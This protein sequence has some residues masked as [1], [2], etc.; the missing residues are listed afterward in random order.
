VKTPRALIAWDDE[1]LRP[2]LGR[3]LQAR[4]FDVTEARTAGG[5][6]EELDRRA[7]SILVLGYLGGNVD[8]L[9]LAGEIRRQDRRTAVI[10]LVSQS[11]EERA[12]SALR[13][14]VLDYF[15]PPF[16]LDAVV[17]SVARTSQESHGTA[18]GGHRGQEDREEPGLLGTSDSIREIKTYIARVGASDSTVLITGETGTGK[19]LTAAL[20]H[21]HSTRCLRPFVCINCAAIPDTLLESELFGFERGA[22]TGAHASRAGQLQQA[23][24]GTIFFDEIG[25]MTP[26]AQPKVLRAIETKEVHRV[27]G[28]S[29]IPV[30]VRVI[31]ATNQDLDQK[32]RDGQFRQ[33][34]FYRLDVARIHLPPLRHRLEDLPVLLEHYVQVFNQRF[35]RRLVGFTT[36]ALA[37]LL[38]YSWPGNIRELRN[39]VEAVYINEPPE[40]ITVRDLPEPFRRRIEETDRLPEDERARILS[41]LFATNWNKSQAAQ[42]LH[43]SRMTL[44]RKIARYRL[45]EIRN[46]L[47]SST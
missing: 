41:A 35:G 24:G 15:T 47:I 26:S 13:L 1:A 18:K 8:L 7:P 32:V 44:Y 46:A 28:R 42:R 29:G 11:S 4:G 20:I 5:L 19:E 31:A 6:R 2:R 38:R 21:R 25:D 34:L 33:D 16:P 3:L 23:E 10:L 27:G 12:V 39:L 43:W 17:A 14:G 40:L 36:E 30:D 37:Y 45:G 9:Q 22:F